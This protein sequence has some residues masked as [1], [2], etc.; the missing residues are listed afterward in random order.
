M[1]VKD[2]LNLDE[3]AIVEVHYDDAQ[4]V[5][6]GSVA[7]VIKS[8]VYDDLTPFSDIPVKRAYCNKYVAPIYSLLNVINGYGPEGK[9]RTIQLYI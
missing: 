4:H 6:Y 9:E 2:F 1:I 5:I 7:K 8:S 3:K